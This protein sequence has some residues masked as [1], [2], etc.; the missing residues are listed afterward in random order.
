MK[1]NP[2]DEMLLVIAL[3]LEAMETNMMWA[4]AES[5]DKNPASYS[6]GR[7]MGIR[8]GLTM[9]AEILRAEHKAMNSEVDPILHITIIDRPCPACQAKPGEP[10]TKAT[11]TGRTPVAWTH[12]ARTRG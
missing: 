6:N 9:A 10:C 3:Q 8:R 5:P 2:T 1:P 7:Y 4:Q 11:D 12:Y